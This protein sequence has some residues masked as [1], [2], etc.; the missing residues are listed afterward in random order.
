MIDLYQLQKEQGIN[1]NPHPRSKLVKDFLKSLSQ[2]ETSRK[3]EIFADRA[4]GSLMEGYHTLKKFSEIC[5][6]FFTKN[7]ESSLRDRTAFMMCHYG[8]LRGDNIRIMELAD[9]FPLEL[10]NEGKILNIDIFSLFSISFIS[11]L[12][13]VH[14]HVNDASARKDQSVWPARIRLRHS[15]QRCRSLLY[16]SF[17]TLL[18]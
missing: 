18:F 8:A 1:N 5:S 7:T 2:Q 4:T 14:C 11:R 16:W 13:E 12:S 3:R 15:S 9:L 17:G 6:T 10:E